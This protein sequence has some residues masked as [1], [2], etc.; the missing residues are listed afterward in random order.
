[1]SKSENNSRH[2]LIRIYQMLQR[3]SDMQNP[4]IITDILPK[5]EQEYGIETCRDSVR[6]DLKAMC[7]CG[8]PIEKKLA[9]QYQFYYEGIFETAELKLLI[10]AVS[11][12]KFITDKESSRLIKKILSTTSKQAAESL[13]RHIHADGRVTTD[14]ESGY[15]IVDAVNEAIEK[16]RRISFQYTDYDGERNRILRHE[17]Q[18][19]VFSPWVLVWDGDYYYMLG[20][21]DDHEKTTTIYRWLFGWGWDGSIV[22]EGPDEVVRQYKKMLRKQTLQ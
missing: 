12:S 15:Y 14:N 6:E 4:M 17:G 11:S 10:D 8:L 7:D 13:T 3:D 1:M 2:R 5:L 9:S 18:I 19:Y 16:G 21:S 22:I 20:W